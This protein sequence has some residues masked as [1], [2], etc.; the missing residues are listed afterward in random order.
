MV[1]VIIEIK[2]VIKERVLVIM[3][4]GVPKGKS[5]INAMEAVKLIWKE[6]NIA[7]K[8]V[9]FVLAMVPK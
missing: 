8:D 9:I 3:V 5:V 7:R 4:I 6:L 1:W 2:R